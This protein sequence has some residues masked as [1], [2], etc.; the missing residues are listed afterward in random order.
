MKRKTAPHLEQIDDTSEA[1]D[2]GN[3]KESFGDESGV[4]GGPVLPRHPSRAVLARLD[5]KVGD[6]A[7]G[8]GGEVEREHHE[9]QPVPP[10]PNVGPD[11]L[12]P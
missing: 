9:V 3:G 1:E 8:E 10:L 7:Q 6:D 12:F 5:L 4:V 2:V 11:A